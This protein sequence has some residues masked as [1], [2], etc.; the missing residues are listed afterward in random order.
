[1]DKEYWNSFYHTGNVEKEPSLFAQYVN[2]QMKEGQS[3]VDLGCG[4]GRDSVYFLKNRLQVY[5]VD[6][7][8]VA[9]SLLAGAYGT[10]I[11][12]INADFVSFLEQYSERFDALYSR[13]TMHAIT[14]E[15]QAHLLTNAYQALK[16]GGKFYIEVRCIEDDL[17][18]KGEEVAR[19]TF[20]Y[21]GHKRRFVVKEELE[22][23]LCKEGFQILSSQ[24]K[25]GFAPYKDVDSIILRIVVIKEEKSR[26]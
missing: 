12:V 2:T 8:E 20:F 1:M 10:Q 11:E 18:G 7:S 22:Q 13:F 21:N 16:P 26:L 9:T 3:I 4:N 19:N 15:D 5:S 25:S 17:Y 24:Q 14:E 23:A 6:A